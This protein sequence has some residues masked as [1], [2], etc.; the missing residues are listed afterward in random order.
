MDASTVRS[1]FFGILR[2]FVKRETAGVFF[3]KFRTQLFNGLL[4]VFFF[5]D[6]HAVL[7]IALF[8]VFESG[9]VL[10]PA[11][12]IDDF[13][14]TAHAHQFGQFFRSQ[15]V[16]FRLIVDFNQVFGFA[17]V[18]LFLDFYGIGIVN[19]RDRAREARR[20]NQFLLPQLEFAFVQFLKLG[21]GK[22]KQLNAFGTFV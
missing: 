15:Y 2:A 14:N 16:I 20:F 8:Q 4:H 12:V 22:G 11:V 6:R 18:L 7:H 3:G 21:V 10:I 1:V 5:H 9:L 19:G 13:G 17:T